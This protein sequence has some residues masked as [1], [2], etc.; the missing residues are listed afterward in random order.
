MLE[1]A[2]LVSFKQM[3]DEFFGTEL[4]AEVRRHLGC[5]R[6]DSTITRMLRSLRARDHLRYRV[7]RI[8]QSKYRKVCFTQN[9]VIACMKQIFS[10][11]ALAPNMRKK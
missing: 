6:M 3:D 7:T 8:H 11:L 5:Y 2:I 4:T 10:R 9:N 1:R